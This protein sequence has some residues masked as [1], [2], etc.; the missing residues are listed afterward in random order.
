MS[1]LKYMEDVGA[2]SVEIIEQMQTSFKQD[3][4]LITLEEEDKIYDCIFGILELRVSEYK[5]YN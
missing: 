3:K 1:R 2:V 5:H 4:I